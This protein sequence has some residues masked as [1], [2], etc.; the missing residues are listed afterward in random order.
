MVC[1]YPE[2]AAVIPGEKPRHPEQS[3]GYLTRHWA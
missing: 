2:Q 3:K 1:S